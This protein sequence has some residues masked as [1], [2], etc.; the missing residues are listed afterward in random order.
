MGARSAVIAHIT[1][2]VSGLLMTTLLDLEGKFG[3]NQPRTLFAALAQYAG[4]LMVLPVDAAVWQLGKGP[5]PFSRGWHLRLILPCALPD[6]LDTFFTM[7]AILNLGGGLFIVVFSFVT[8]AVALLRRLVLRRSP[9]RVQWLAVIVITA[10]IAASGA[11]TLTANF[12]AASLLGLLSALAAAA[13]DAVLYVFAE[14]ALSATEG[15]SA[16]E[17]T[18]ISAI[19]NLSITSVYVLS[20]AAAG[21]WQEWVVEP[22]LASHCHS[23]S[24][25][26]V[27]T[28]VVLGLAYWAHYQSFYLSVGGSNAVAAG[29][30]KALQSASIF[31][32]AHVLFCD[33]GGFHGGIP[34]PCRRANECLTPLKIASSAAVFLGTVLYGVGAQQRGTAAAET[35]ADDAEQREGYDPPLLPERPWPVTSQVQ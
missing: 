8:V 4:M 23:S 33:S 31:F 27:G 34:A 24:S 11:S 2:Y 6:L 28:W 17:L 12:S 22:L 29:V 15:P 30:N 35:V 3:S 32:T 19:I 1:F 20:Y 9:T 16:N 26:V 14:R 7:Y 5:P 25:A 13:C 21:Q 10:G 18:Y